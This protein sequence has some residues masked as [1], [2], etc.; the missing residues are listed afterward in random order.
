M[1]ESPDRVVNQMNSALRTR[2][3]PPT[4]VAVPEAMLSATI[5]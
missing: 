2:R 4:R 1:L 3:S 5:S